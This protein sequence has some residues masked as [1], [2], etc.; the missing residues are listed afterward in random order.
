ME[1]QK[2]WEQLSS[3]KILLFFITVVERC[4]VCQLH[5]FNNVKVWALVSTKLREVDTYQILD[6]CSGS[7][8]IKSVYVQTMTS[9]LKH[10]TSTDNSTVH[11]H[12][13]TLAWR[14]C[15]VRRWPPVAVWGAYRHGWALGHGL[16]REG[17]REK[18]KSKKREK[19]WSDEKLEGKRR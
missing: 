17:K 12:H 16:K 5:K 3:Y 6:R 4:N 18:N 10:S 9:H 2:Y 13:A 19:G 8:T 15:L 14:W 11:V 1:I 7:C